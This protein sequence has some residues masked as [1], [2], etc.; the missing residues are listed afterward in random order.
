MCIRDRYMRPLY[1]A[2]NDLMGNE[3]YLKNLEKGLIEVSPLAYMRGRTLDD[4]LLYTS[5]CV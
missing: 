1:D 3:Q 2:L 5:R 4:C